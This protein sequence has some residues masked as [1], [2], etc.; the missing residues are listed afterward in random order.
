MKKLLALFLV[1]LLLAVPVS[2][3]GS[4]V[5]DDAELMPD[6]DAE[7]LEEIYGE[8]PYTHGF[9]PILVTTDSF[10]G[11]SAEEFAG[12]FYDVMEYP[13]DGILLLVSLEEGQWYILTN[14][15]CYD[16]ISDG[17]AEAIGEELVPMIQDGTYYA[18]FLKFPEL[19]A[20]VFEANAPA[21]E[22]DEG[23]AVA[24]AVPKKTYGKTIAIC[25][26]VGMVVGLITVGIMASQMKSVRAQNTAS[27]YV[28]P[29]S[30]DLTH[31]RDIFLYS[32]VT[33]T[34]K[35]KNNSSGGHSGGGSRGGA[36]G[37]L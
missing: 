18:A 33:R 4:L 25:M 16:R 8:Y 1:L 14:G 36:G 7:K 3:S 35:P 6:H 5:Q 30:M 10:G 2:A 32:H 17:E 26:A 23:V 31:S 9:T 29:G 34:A 19:A 24:P 13:Q 21:T 12:E 27:D 37:R 11:L 28:R 15:E 22:E 20:E